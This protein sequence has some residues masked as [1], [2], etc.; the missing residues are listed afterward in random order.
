[1]LKLP[2]DSINDV[3]YK[4]KY[5]QITQSANNQKTNFKNIL[6][7]II[8]VLI[9]TKT[10][11]ILTI[12]SD[13][14][15]DDTIITPKVFYQDFDY[16]KDRTKI[17]KYNL[18]ALWSYEHSVKRKIAQ[19]E[20][21]RD[22]QIHLDG[23]IN[24]DYVFVDRYN[25]DNYYNRGT[26][27]NNLELLALFKVNNTDIKKIK[28]PGV[29]FSSSI[30]NEFNYEEG[31]AKIVLHEKYKNP[32]FYWRI[33]EIFNSENHF[34]KYRK[35]EN[36]KE[37]TYFLNVIDDVNEHPFFYYINNVGKKARYFYRPFFEN[38]SDTLLLALRI[39][40]T[41]VYDKYELAVCSI[42]DSSFYYKE[43]NIDL[44][45]NIIVPERKNFL[46]YTLNVFCFLIILFLIAGYWLFILLFNDYKKQL[47]QYSLS[48]LLRLAIEILVLIALLILLGW[49]FI[50]AKGFLWPGLILLII[51]L[52]II[53]KINCLR[54]LKPHIQRKW[55]IFSIQK[56]QQIITRI[57][58]QK[59]LRR[60][61]QYARKERR[62]WIINN[63][64]GKLYTLSRFFKYKISIWIN[65]IK[66]KIQN[67][68]LNIKSIFVK[69]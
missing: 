56:K 44:K 23:V 51:A 68:I 18:I 42:D 33:K 31:N 61:K 22:F 13:F 35:F 34:T 37:A 39:D 28:E 59:V 46:R 40:G 25:D 1:L 9:K 64:K 6:D 47:F 14:Y 52:M 57:N 63:I 54:K 45:K 69:K 20:L 11:N 27:T 10:N 32:H 66:E 2:L 16:F 17:E 26:T 41:F 30:S 50:S 15:H 12:F 3:K 7:S 5:S 48:R 62:K 49:F 19:N 4:A 29:T 53:G 67:L 58:N 65:K 21:I 24:T 36:D 60:R 38:S 55:K 8:P 43:F